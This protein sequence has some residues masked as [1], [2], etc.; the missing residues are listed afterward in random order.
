MPLSFS[1]AGVDPMVTAADASPPGVPRLPARVPTSTAYAG[2]YVR[3]V[4]GKQRVRER[5]WRTLEIAGA[6][7]FPG[8]RGRIPNFR[9]AE[10]AAERL[11]Q[12]PEW[13]AAARCGGWRC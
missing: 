8:A 2:G 3:P 10:A 4:E 6:A 1:N 7:R 11:A 12:L 13:A 9:G 5:I